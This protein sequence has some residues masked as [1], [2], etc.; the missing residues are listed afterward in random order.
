MI[1]LRSR[2]LAA[3][4]TD[5]DNGQRQNCGQLNLDDEEL[6]LVKRLLHY[7][8]NSN[9]DG[10]WHEGQESWK[11][12]LV[13][14][15]E[16][17]QENAE[18][19]KLEEVEIVDRM[20]APS[21][22]RSPSSSGGVMT[23]WG[24]RFQPESPAYAYDELQAPPC[25]A[26]SADEKQFE[27]KPYDEQVS[28][29]T[30]PDVEPSLKCSAGDDSTAL[31][32]KEPPMFDDTTIV[33]P[34][35]TVKS[36][37]EC[38]AEDEP[39]RDPWKVWAPYLSKKN[40]K[41]IESIG[42]MPEYDLPVM[43]KADETK[44]I[45]DDVPGPPEDLSTWD[46]IATSKEKKKKKK[47]GISSYVEIY[48]DVEPAVVKSDPLNAPYGFMEATPLPDDDCTPTP[49]LASKM[50]NG[51]RAR[52][53]LDELAVPAPIDEPK[54]P[55]HTK[56]MAVE[57]APEEVEPVQLDYMDEPAEQESIPELGCMSD[58]APVLKKIKS[59]KSKKKPKKN[60]SVA[61]KLG[62]EPILASEVLH[63]PTLSPP[64][65]VPETYDAPAAEPYKEPLPAIEKP[66]TAAITPAPHPSL[67]LNA[68]M[69]LLACR[70]D[71]PVLEKLAIA[72]FKDRLKVAWNSADFALC[73][74][75]IYAGDVEGDARALR[76][77]VVE[78]AWHE[79]R[80][81]K[82]RKD[83]MDLLQKE[84]RFGYDLLNRIDVDGNMVSTMSA[85]G[86]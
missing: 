27:A 50:D 40:Q 12:D 9:Y 3:R 75:D 70:Y 51:E 73:V 5:T 77:L 35:E 33:D 4:I 16:V 39:E 24:P 8:Y 15:I 67:L 11:A 52:A 61:A 31:L 23:G 45:I 66:P 57:P 6:V 48:P 44:D 42:R 1:H 55:V 2:R 60:K 25:T 71:M 58:K 64:S 80:A 68:R 43:E 74:A 21:T 63:S 34:N 76:D 82:M 20:T 54:Q 32:A 36:A 79:L 83:F 13:G 17:T 65:A 81:L 72:K 7:I 18:K 59:S 86:N 85:L 78:T 41:S 69:Y 14:E 49:A 28:E 19:N 37:A 10:I 56:T 26:D 62:I 46:L 22:H 29:E 47:K 38:S 30:C 84:L 53:A